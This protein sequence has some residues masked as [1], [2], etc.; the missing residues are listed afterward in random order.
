MENVFVTRVILEITAYS[1]QVG[2]TS[3]IKTTRKYFV[4]HAIVPVKMLVRKLA[5]KVA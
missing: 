1:A 4:L 3:L 2:F 5:Q